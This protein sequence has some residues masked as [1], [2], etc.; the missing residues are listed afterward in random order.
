MLPPS[1]D[2]DTVSRKGWEFF[3]KF[4]F[5]NVV[6]TIVALVIVA[7]LTVWS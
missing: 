3:T 6:A 5:G 4:L 1:E 2:F 7:L